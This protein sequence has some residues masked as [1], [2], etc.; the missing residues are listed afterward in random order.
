MANRGQSEQRLRW[1]LS[2]LL[3]CRSTSQ[4]VS[5]L[6]EREGISRRSARRYVARAYIEMVADLEDA[7][8]DRKQM[9]ALCVHALQQTM[10][11]ALEAG[12]GNAV[13]GAVRALNELIDLRPNNLPQQAWSPPA[14]WKK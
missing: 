6:A 2:Q 7:Q 12:H 11:Q 1:C 8:I 5:E 13:V 10:A 3:R 4:I 14:E 9:V